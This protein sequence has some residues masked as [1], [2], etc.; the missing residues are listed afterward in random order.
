MT[1][2]DEKLTAEERADIERLPAHAHP[3][4]SKLLRLYDAALA[5]ITELEAEVQDLNWQAMGEDL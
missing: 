5:R 1:A 2:P 4:L 3:C